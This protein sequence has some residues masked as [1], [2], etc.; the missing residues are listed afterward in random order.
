MQVDR[1]FLN[2]GLFFILLGAVPLLVQANVLDRTAVGDAWRL[3]PIVIIGWGVGLVLN[4]TPVAMLGGVIVAG[5]LGIIVGGLLSVGPSFTTLGCGT[6]TG[7]ATTAAD[8]GTFGGPADVRIHMAC[9]V[10]T[11]NAQ[12]GSAWSLSTEDPQSGSAIVSKSANLL[13]VR[14]KGGFDF[15]GFG[16]SDRHWTVSLPTDTQLNLTVEVNAGSG[17]IRLPQARISELQG[18][19]NASDVK[20]DLS[21]ASIGGIDMEWN[22]ASGRLKL[23]AGSSFSGTVKVNA[24]SLHLCTPQGVGL[25]LVTSGA[26]SS[27]DFGSAGL[28]QS[29]GTWTSNDYTT[30]ANRIDLTVDANLGSVDLNSAGGCQ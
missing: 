26:L 14:A 29:G 25:R 9:G 17:D 5:T 20:V 27:T 24:G 28:A 8:S 16:H 6:G 22:A 13:D 11:M 15:L 10:L 30:A 3:W 19:F 12:S 7:G 21:G 18:N 23:P 4:R 2:W 1:R